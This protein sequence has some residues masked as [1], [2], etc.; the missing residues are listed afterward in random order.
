MDE[1]IRRLERELRLSGRS[2]AEWAAAIL[3]EENHGCIFAHGGRVFVLGN[4]DRCITRQEV[5]YATI[6]DGV[7]AGARYVRSTWAIEVVRPEA[8]YDAAILG[9]VWPPAPSVK[10]APPIDDPE[11]VQA[12]APEL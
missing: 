6:Y 7:P 5:H 2:L 12:P 1:T 3:A 8:E 11:P 10:D 4:L 9:C